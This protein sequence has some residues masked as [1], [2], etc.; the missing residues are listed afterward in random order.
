MSSADTSI[1]TNIASLAETSLSL[2]EETQQ[3]NIEL[4]FGRNEF[5]NLIE[6][7]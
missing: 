5:D 2:H 1:D 3:Q 7:K 4:V 6:I